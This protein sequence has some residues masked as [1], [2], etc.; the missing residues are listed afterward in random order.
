MHFLTYVFPG[1]LHYIQSRNG[2]KILA[3]F[4]FQET[5]WHYEIK[6]QMAMS[7]MATVKER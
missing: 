3:L 5:P 4:Y 1:N 7:Q 6:K 2:I